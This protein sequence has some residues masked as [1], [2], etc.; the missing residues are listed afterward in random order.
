MSECTYHPQ[1]PYR[2]CRH[3]FSDAQHTYIAVRWG[4]LI[5]RGGEGWLTVSGWIDA[6]GSFGGSVT[7]PEDVMG[8]AVQQ[9]EG[10]Q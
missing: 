3:R 5:T 7:G 6:D 4:E 10:V 8:W 1:P 9:F 2:E